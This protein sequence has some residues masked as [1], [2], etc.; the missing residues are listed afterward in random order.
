M[1]EGHIDASANKQ[2]FSNF[3]KELRENDLVCWGVV[4]R[5]DSTNFRKA[6]MLVFASLISS[7]TRSL[8]I[9]HGTQKEMKAEENLML[10]K[11]VLGLGFLPAKAKKPYYLPL[12]YQEIHTYVEQGEK[13]KKEKVH[14]NSL[15]S[16]LWF[17]SYMFAKDDVSLQEKCEAVKEFISSDTHKVCFDLQQSIKI[18]LCL[19]P[20]HAG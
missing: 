6:D 9:S 15:L 16:T 17:N 10:H 13:A 14:I 19:F 5:Y 1:P 4:Y 20:R 12:T 3:L 8:L 7:L 2:T 18:P 11:L